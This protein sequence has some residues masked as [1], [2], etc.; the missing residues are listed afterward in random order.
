M[1]SVSHLSKKFN[2]FSIL[3]LAYLQKMWYDIVI[4][5]IKNTEDIMIVVLLILIV[6]S[7]LFSVRKPLS[8]VSTKFD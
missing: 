3:S 8:Q 5:F 7:A 1:E 4:H 2:I 6:L